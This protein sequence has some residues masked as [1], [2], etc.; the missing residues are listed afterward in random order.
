MARTVVETT[1]TVTVTL[2][3]IGAEEVC[4]ITEV[5]SSGGMG[6]Y[7]AKM[8]NDQ[9]HLDGAPVQEWPWEAPDATDTYCAAFKFQ[10]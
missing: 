5:K 9:R 7:I 3:V 8:I 4:I 6:C 2:P 10:A 1:E